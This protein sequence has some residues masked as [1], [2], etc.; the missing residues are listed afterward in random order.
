M[1]RTG[2][3]LFAYRTLRSGISY[4]SGYRLF[5]KEG[6][7]YLMADWDRQDDRWVET[8]SGF[9][10]AARLEVFERLGG[11][12]EKLFLY[13]EEQDMSLQLLKAG[14]K[15]RYL[16][17]VRILHHGAQSVAA[18]PHYRRRRYWLESFVHLRHKQGLSVSAAT[19]RLIL[20]PVLWTWWLMR[21]CRGSE[22]SGS[23]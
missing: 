5:R 4:L 15:I 2:Y 12:D 8:V 10:W 9:A 18:T 22:A 6:R 20:Y 23:Y 11:F 7:R 16:A 19:D 1:G 3:G 17:G 13:F 14:F 21:C